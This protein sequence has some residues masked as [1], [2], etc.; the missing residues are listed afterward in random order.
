MKPISLANINCELAD[1]LTPL[2]FL[3]F[4]SELINYVFVL[5][6]FWIFSLYIIKYDLAFFYDQ[7]AYCL[8]PK[9]KAKI[10]KKQ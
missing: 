3:R 2:S 1:F 8:K 4:A 7:Q 6:I 5:G 9:L 10:K